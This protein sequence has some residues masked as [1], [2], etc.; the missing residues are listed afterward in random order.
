MK[1]MNT[2]MK[3]YVTMIVLVLVTAGS[4]GAQDQAKPGTEE[5]GLTPKQLVQSIEKV[6]TMISKCM[7]EQ[8]FQYIAVDADTVR[9]GMDADKTLPG[10]SE[11]EFI[12]KY[13]Y[14]L[15]TLYT[16]KPP[17]LSTGYCPAKT[18]LGKRNVQIYQNLSAAD[19]VAYN[20]ALLGEN[21]DATFAVALELENFARTGGCT[22]RAIEQVF[23]PDQLKA[24]Y[25]NPLDAM[26]NKDPRMQ[27]ALR[28][29]AAGM[30]KAG[31]NYNHPDEVEPDIRERLAALTGEGGILIENMSPEQQAAL[32]Q[33]QTYEQQVAVK[34]LELTEEF[35]DPVEAKIEKEMYPRQIQ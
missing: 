31:F 9:K 4:A 13:G 20:R 16:G 1:S 10:L 17:Q 6:E 28:Q 3:S 26:I 8:G 18:S 24:T 25:Y 35:I 11:D 5:F 19:Q 12:G 7:R 29:Y 2:L 33:L 14:G 27:A 32:K 30:R 15:A 34:N 21:T 22:R 23:K